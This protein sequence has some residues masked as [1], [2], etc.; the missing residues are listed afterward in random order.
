MSHSWQSRKL[1]HQS[2]RALLRVSALP[3]RG[4]A[5]PSQCK[6]ALSGQP[7][8][9]SCR[10]PSSTKKRSRRPGLS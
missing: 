4:F 2:W 7:S 9:P 3:R 6:S 8:G 1:K 5:G 10:P